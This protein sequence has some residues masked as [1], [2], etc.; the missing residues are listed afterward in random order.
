MTKKKLRLNG[1]YFEG[2]NA[3]DIFKDETG[4]TYLKKVKQKKKKK[5]G[6]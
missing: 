2:K 1:Y 5:N 4:N 6:K 3:Y